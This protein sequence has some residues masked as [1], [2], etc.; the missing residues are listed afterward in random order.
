MRIKRLHSAHGLNKSLLGSSR[1]EEQGMRI[2]C[3]SSSYWEL[4][5]MHTTRL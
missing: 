5:I 2:K 1:L 4:G 3:L